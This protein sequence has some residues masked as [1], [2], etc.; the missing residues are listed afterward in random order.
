VVPRPK[1]WHTVTSSMFIDSVTFCHG[2][3]DVMLLAQ[4][5]SSSRILK[6]LEVGIVSHP[7][8]ITGN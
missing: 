4:T 7:G 5:F 1:V 2:Y 8:A 6:F 3:V